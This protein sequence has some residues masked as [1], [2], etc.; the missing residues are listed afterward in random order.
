MLFLT[1]Y[2]HRTTY[3]VLVLLS[4]QITWRFIVADIDYREF[5]K[6]R[7]TQLR[8]DRH[9]SEYQLSLDLDHNR[10]YIQSISSGKALPSM[11]EFLKICEY[12]ELTPAQF[13]DDSFHNSDLIN[14]ALDGMKGL[15]YNDMILLIRLIERLNNKDNSSKA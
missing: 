8:L 1:N 14:K 12:F 11:K 7:I 13:F 15:D 4:Q 9:L 5:I 2:I 3:L 6:N 10:T